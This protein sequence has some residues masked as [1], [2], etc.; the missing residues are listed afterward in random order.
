[1]DGKISLNYE[2]V[3]SL[4]PQVWLKQHL[5]D[6]F[7]KALSIY[8]DVAKGKTVILSPTDLNAISLTREDKVFDIEKRQ[9]NRE[10]HNYVTYACQSFNERI[11]KANMVYMIVH[12]DVDHYFFVELNMVKAKQ[13]CSFDLLIADSY[14][15][16]T[17]RTW[18]QFFYMLQKAKVLLLLK[19]IRPHFAIH[20]MKEKMFPFNLILLNVKFTA[21]EDYTAL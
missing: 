14:Y 2:S 21:A 6:A 10:N 17:G 19:E 5:I 7:D 1:M 11:N 12:N 9:N 8:P 15:H 3:R 4:Q 20:S 16:E 13:N 18:R